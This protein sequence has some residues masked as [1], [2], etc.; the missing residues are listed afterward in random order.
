MP[1]KKKAST[2]T[3]AIETGHMVALAL[4]PDTAPLRSYVGQVIA[5][6]ERGIRITTMDWSMDSPTGDDFYAPWSSITSMLVATEEH[7]YDGFLKSAAAFRR[8]MNGD[9]DPGDSSA[10]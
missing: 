9:A 2:A 4:A 10:S 6:D 5:L 7:D 3:P 1:P 8:Q